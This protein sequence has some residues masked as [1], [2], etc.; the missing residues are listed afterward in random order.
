MASDSVF[1]T[2]VLKHDQTIGL[3]Q[4]AA[5]QAEKEWWWGFPPEG[6]E[7]ISWVVAMG[8]GQ[9]VSLRVPLELVQQVNI[10]IERRAWGVFSTDFYITYDFLATRERITREWESRRGLPRDAQP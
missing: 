5:H 2:I 3:D 4:R 9:I 6:C 10:E 8:L 1:L 7:V